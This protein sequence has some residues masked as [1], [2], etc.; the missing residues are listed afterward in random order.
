MK[1]QR[2]EKLARQLEAI[3]KRANCV[4][5][6]VEEGEDCIDVLY[7]LQA[8]RAALNKIKLELLEDYLEHWTVALVQGE[9]P[10]HYAHMLKEFLILFNF[11]ERHIRQS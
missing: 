1:T 6:M 8:M 5:R 9:G 7:H 4:V 2:C 11:A 3:S 10:E